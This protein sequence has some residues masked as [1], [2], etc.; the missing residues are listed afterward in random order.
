M[1]ALARACAMLPVMVDVTEDILDAA[2]TNSDDLDLLLMPLYN[3][4]G[5]LFL[6]RFKHATEGIADFQRVIVPDVWQPDG[7]RFAGESW[8]PNFI[9]SPK[10][11]NDLPLDLTW[12]VTA[13]KPVV[14]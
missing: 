4:M 2:L 5:P 10:T 6:N 13:P 7:N 3:M 1:F 8:I 14:V 12:E 9:F 11:R